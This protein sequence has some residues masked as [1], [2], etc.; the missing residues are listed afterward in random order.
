MEGAEF[1]P[2][3]FQNM[4]I[5]HQHWQHENEATVQLFFESGAG[6]LSQP[7]APVPRFEAGLMQWPPQRG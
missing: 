5:T 1:P 6:D 4:R 2:D 3:R 7:G